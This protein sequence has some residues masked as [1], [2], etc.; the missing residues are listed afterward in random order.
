MNNEEQQ[1]L[2]HLDKHRAS[3]EAEICKRLMRL[4][5]EG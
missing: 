3:L 4:G 5:Y 1:F 2:N